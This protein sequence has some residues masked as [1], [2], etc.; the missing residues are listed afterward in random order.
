[1]SVR[2]NLE[3]LMFKHATSVFCAALL[4]LPL[5][6]CGND[7][8]GDGVIVSAFPDEGFA[9]R[10]TSLIIVGEFTSFSNASTVDFGPGITVGPVM[11]VGGTGLIV[12]VTAALDAPLGAR[13]IT[14]DG[15]T[16]AD[17][18]T[19][20]SPIDVEVLGT[21][22]Q[23]SFS[24]VK[25]TNLDVLNPFDLTTDDDGAFVN[26]TATLSTP[27][28]S[29]VVG[30]ASPFE[31]ELTLQLDVNATPGSASI[32][33]SSGPAAA[34]ILSRTSVDVV[35]RTPMPI[36][37]GGTITGSVASGFDSVLY[38]LTTAELTAVLM[39][40][41][42]TV[43]GSAFLQILGPSGSFDEPI[44]ASFNSFFGPLN[45]SNNI[46]AGQKVFVI[47]WDGLDAAGYDYSFDV[48]LIAATATI[49]HA[50]P[51]DAP[52]AAQTVVAP[53]GVLDASFT[54]DTDEDWYA[55]QV[56][57]GDVGKAITVVT[58]GSGGA[59]PV[60]EIFAP[61]GTTS[62]GG[63]EDAAFFD[64]LT[65]GP[66]TVAGK[67]LVRITSSDFAPTVP[68]DSAYTVVIALE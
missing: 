60:I 18:F 65:S 49:T 13:P 44:G 58:G 24:I 64:R 3:V 68:D 45:F 7:D 50:E 59:D 5:A 30:N 39:S 47:L 56:A 26:L 21:P 54:G 9:G 38:E 51:N 22:A 63:P 10:K 19:L 6:A 15:L 55:I 36:G 57:A 62:L 27:G 8:D 4:A 33:V 34:A 17:G 23:G 11:A 16:L 52:A 46:A 42:D 29:V 2:Q 31:L 35:A 43:A 25:V 66:T 12:E 14:V 32:D 67:H 40:V 28:G 53:G 20:A 61:D 48:N 41:P 37:A 1:M